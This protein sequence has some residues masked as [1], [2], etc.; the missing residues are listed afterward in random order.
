MAKDLPY[1]KFFCSEWNDG[2]ITLESYEAQGL[3]INICSYYWSNECNITFK[4]LL[5]RFRNCEETINE[6]K[7]AELIKI[8]TEGNVFINFLNEQKDEREE[9]RK[10]K[11]KG[12][13]ASADARKLRKLQQESN[14]NPTEIKKVLNSSSTEKQHVLNSCSTE[15]QLLREEKIREEEIRKEKIITT[16]EVDLGVNDLFKNTLLKDSYVLGEY[17]RV[18][19]TNVKTIKHYINLFRS[20]L[21]TTGET[22]ENQKDY[23]VHF[24]NWLRRQQIQTIKEKAVNPYKNNLVGVKPLK[25]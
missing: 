19:K 17:S 22:K 11:V 18:F 21:I 5:K 10:A 14:K 25:K 2:D 16:K 20:H 24:G 12:G 23:Q 7:E 1:F 9:S 4:K 8:D 15:S 3:F 13:K 6:L